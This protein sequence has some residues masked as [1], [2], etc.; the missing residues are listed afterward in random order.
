MAI[1]GQYTG[2]NGGK[3][4]DGHCNTTPYLCLYHGQ[5]ECAA[6]VHL[7]GWHSLFVLGMKGIKCF[8][9]SAIQTFC[10]G[11]NTVNV[12]ILARIHFHGFQVY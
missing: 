3:Y 10:E 5:V 12:D 4:W 7:S 8:Y 9:C 11:F 1:Y 6:G 2:D